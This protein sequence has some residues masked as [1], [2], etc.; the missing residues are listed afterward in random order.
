MLRLR[1]N[2][3]L[4]S[5][6][7]VCA[8]SLLSLIHKYRYDSVNI[9]NTAGP[10]EEYK[11]E[12]VDLNV[13]P[14]NIEKPLPRINNTSALG[15]SGNKYPPSILLWTTWRSGSTFI[16][17]LLAEASDNTFYSYEP[18]MPLG[19]RIYRSDT[20]ETR[21]AVQYLSDILHCNHDRQ[22]DL[23]RRLRHHSAYMNGNT[24]L[25]N[26]C[27]PVD[28]C[29]DASF[30]S[31]VCR[32]ATVHVL[33]VLRLALTWA[34]MLLD[35]PTLNL[36]IIYVTR[37]PRALLRYHKQLVWFIKCLT[38]AG[39]TNCIRCCR[40]L[41]ELSRSGTS[42]QKQ[43]N[44]F[45]YQDR[46]R[47]LRYEDFSLD[48]FGQVKELWHFLGLTLSQHQLEVIH[49]MS[50]LEAPTNLTA[51]R[52]RVLSQRPKKSDMNRIMNYTSIKGFLELLNIIQAL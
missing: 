48:V 19:V 21:N 25:T 42:C 39:N 4:L 52:P 33:K 34:P 20:T 11:K 51:R 47:F 31:G 15:A 41:S 35:D 7:G 36:K 8:G 2:K 23:V 30:I 32:N 40:I 22:R 44:D 29:S 14:G 24:L 12:V 16:G 9:F 50:N 17:S 3:I 37:D 28:R 5:L 18:M 49:N 46:F 43:Y 27:R 45:I 10:F 1:R 13:I 6:I 26:A 38:G